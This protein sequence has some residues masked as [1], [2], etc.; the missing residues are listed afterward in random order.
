MY[1]RVFL[2]FVLLAGLLGSAAP[3]LAQGQYPR[4][5]YYPD[6]RPL[7]SILPEIRRDHPGRFYDAEGPY[8]DGNGG[9]HYRL[10][11]MT[12]DGRI[13]WFD[14]DARSGRVIGPARNN[15]PEGGWAPPPPPPIYGPANG[16]R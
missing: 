3:S 2:A 1:R 14:T 6:A 10:K 16:G 8:P 13:V 5:R 9:L 15:W 12:P 7:Y 4:D 11:W